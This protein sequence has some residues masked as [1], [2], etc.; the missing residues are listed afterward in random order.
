MLINLI[1][2]AFK[3]TPSGGTIKVKMSYSNEIE[4]LIV[5]VQD[6]GVGITKEDMLNINMIHGGVFKLEKTTFSPQEAFYF[7]S[8]IF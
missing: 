3:F 5:H 4:C 6:T 7:V 2:N 8:D 1:K